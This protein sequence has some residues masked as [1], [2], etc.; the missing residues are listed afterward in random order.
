MDDATRFRE[1]FESSHGAV[2]RYVY[3]RGVTDGAADDVV[4]ETFL[5]TWRR[6]DAVPDDDPVPC[7]LAVARNVWLNQRRGDRRR[8]AFLR[9]LPPP[10]PVPPPDE[11]AEPDE[12][13][14][15][16]AALSALAADDQEILRL[17]TWDG[18]TGAQAARVLG[19]S[20]GA[21]RVRLHRARRRLAE[22]MEKRS[23]SVGQESV[24]TDPIREVSDERA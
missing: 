10:A 12:V 20:A 17:V 15:V 11:P 5:V 19:C 14:A 13:L 22:E 3:H 6:L 4:A 7:L 24:E 16:R 18:L 21:A 23:W 9:R 2:Q 1:L 8:S